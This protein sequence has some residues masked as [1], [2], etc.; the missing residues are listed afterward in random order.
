MAGV[1]LDTPVERGRVTL[2]L[3]KGVRANPD[4]AGFRNVKIVV[5]GGLTQERIRS[6][7][8]AGALVDV[9]AVGSH[10]SD[11]QPIDFT[12]DLH[13]VDGRPVSKRGRL[14]GLTPSPKLKRIL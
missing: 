5:S 13:E 11:A 12:A 10:I 6:F 4:L 9:F 1:R 7:V 2:D 8:E 14:P 3:V